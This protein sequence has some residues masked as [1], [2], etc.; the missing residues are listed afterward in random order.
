MQQSGA[1]STLFAGDDLTDEDGFAVLSNTDV[2]IRV[3]GGETRAPY[4]L[5][6]PEEVADVLWQIHDARLALDAP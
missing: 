2:A 3:G 6:S 1:S 5:A 4:R